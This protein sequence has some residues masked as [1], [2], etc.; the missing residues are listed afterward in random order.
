[1]MG[2]TEYC[3]MI[4]LPKPPQNLPRVSLFEPA[5]L[6]CRLPRVSSKRKL[7][8]MQGAAWRT[9]HLTISR[10][11]FQ[12]S[13]VQVLW[14]F[15]HLSFP[16]SNQR[17]SSCSP[18]VDVGFVKLTSDSFCGNSDLKMN[19]QFFCHL[20]C[21]RFVIFR[22]NPSLCTTISFCQCWFSSTVPLPWYCLPMIRVCR[23]NLRNCRSRDT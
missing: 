14:S 8:L 20:C 17:F 21:S 10:A 4:L 1:M 6:D 12:L 16:F 2:P 11:H 5:I 23:H 22:N 7:S 13:D 15:A 18:T 9:T 19:I 3:T